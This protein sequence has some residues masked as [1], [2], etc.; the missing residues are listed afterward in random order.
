MGSVVCL[1]YGHV[2]ARFQNKMTWG[3]SEITGGAA[4]VGLHEQQWPATAMKNSIDGP[5]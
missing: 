4:V 5:Q 2:Q 1:V 3:A